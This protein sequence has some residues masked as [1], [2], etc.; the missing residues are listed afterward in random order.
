VVNQVGH[1]LGKDHGMGAIGPNHLDP[2]YGP[3]TRKAFSWKK[4]IATRWEAKIVN[5]PF[6]GV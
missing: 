6:L 5:G 3:R 2:N 1:G 4:G